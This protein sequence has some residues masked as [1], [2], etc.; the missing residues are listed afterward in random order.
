M[1]GRAARSVAAQAS[2]SDVA[3]A[4]ARQD[5]CSIVGRVA[6]PVGLV[7]A[8]GR[9]ED[10]YAPALAGC[11]EV[12]FVAV[13]GRSREPVRR[14][15]AEHGAVACERFEDL[16]ERCA[17]VVFAVPPPVQEQYAARAAGRGRALLLEKPIGADLAGAEQLTSV[18]VREQVP[19][20]VALPWRF[21]AEAGR[22][23]Q[24]EAPAVDPVGGIGRLLTGTHTPGA[25]TPAWRV[26]RGVLRDQASDLVDLL[27][28]ALG[29]VVGVHGHGDPRG[30]VGLQLDHQV[31]R[32]S[33]A[34]LY[35]GLTK[36]PDV[37]FV[38]VTGPQGTAQVEALG[39]VGPA[40]HQRM[41]A[42]FARAVTD[43]RPH[44]L[45]IEHGLHLQRL[46]EAAETDLVLHG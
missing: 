33:Q 17:A 3:T 2:G 8:G 14:L 34:Q 28:A 35:A 1:C 29:P 20:M 46:V 12:D 41:I 16:L 31:G 32:F 43:R 13:W 23:L 38:E 5:R 26:A 25:P 18:A 37:A 19:T 45:G 30:W 24:V 39:A 6:V 36:G 27:E 11:P 42:Q 4:A 21:S 22:F 40:C 44:P 9:A 10:V 7:G 15:A